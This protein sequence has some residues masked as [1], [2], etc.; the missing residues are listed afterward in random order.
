VAGGK[1]TGPRRRRAA[2]L[3]NRL[4]F[5]SGVPS[6][7]PFEGADRHE[8]DE[9][10]EHAEKL[11]GQLH[12]L[13]PCDPCMSCSRRRKACTGGRVENAGRRGGYKRPVKARMRMTMRMRPRRP[14][15]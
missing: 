12:V 3:L 5:V 7:D 1:A 14:L 10:T 9:R 11:D 2:R 13:P 8:D 6:A 4:C 15:G